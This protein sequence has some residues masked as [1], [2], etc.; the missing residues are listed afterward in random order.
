MIH[1]TVNYATKPHFTLDSFTIFNELMDIKNSDKNVKKK[2][3][4][5]VKQ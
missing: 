4:Q 2:N 3:C 5:K 1:N